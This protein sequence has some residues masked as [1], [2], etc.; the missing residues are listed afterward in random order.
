MED[1]EVKTKNHRG[2]INTTVSYVH[3]TTNNITLNKEQDRI[4]R[5]FDIYKSAFKVYLNRLRAEKKAITSDP[6]YKKV[7]DK[8]FRATDK[9][10][11]SGLI[12]KFKK[13]IVYFTDYDITNSEQWELVKNSNNKLVY[14]NKTKTRAPTIRDHIS[15]LIEAI[16]FFND[17]FSSKEATIQRILNALNKDERYVQAYDDLKSFFTRYSGMINSIYRYYGWPIKKLE[18]DQDF[19][20]LIQEWGGNSKNIGTVGKDL[21]IKLGYLAEMVVAS[22]EFNDKI[23]EVEDETIRNF[24]IAK[25]NAPSD[26]IVDFNEEKIKVQLKTGKFTSYGLR[27]TRKEYLKGKH[28]YNYKTLGLNKEEMITLSN[29]YNLSFNNLQGS[30]QYSEDLFYKYLLNIV[31]HDVFSK[32]SIEEVPNIIVTPYGYY[33]YADLLEDHWSLLL[34]G[35]P[36]DIFNYY[37]QGG[38]SG[39][40]MPNINNGLMY[41]NK[42]KAKD[43]MLAE[44]EK[45]EENLK[46]KQ[47]YIENYDYGKEWSTFIGKIISFNYSILDLAY[48]L[49]DNRTGYKK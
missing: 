15:N 40:K 33:F 45:Q 26:I 42:L 22:N 10:W 38:L 17:L 12:D 8:L 29:I 23:E 43:E 3:S 18:V 5:E 27:T 24:L 1:K 47:Y 6:N 13:A 34:N 4:V 32:F 25:K 28:A 36:Q 41:R 37:V 2:R 7:L 9:Q 49:T 44:Q 20:D 39:I 35:S 19:I 46:F 21:S 48:Q 11:I 30:I 14:K 16:E 31:F